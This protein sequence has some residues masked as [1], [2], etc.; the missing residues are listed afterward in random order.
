KAAPKAKDTA[1]KKATPKETSATLSAM[2]LAERIGIQFDLAWTGHFNG[3]ING[4]SGERTAA[5][6]KAFQKEYRVKESGAL[7][8]AERAQLA[9]A[10]KARQERVAWRMAD[11]KAT[12]A[13]LGLPTLQVPNV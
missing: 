8:P 3:L 7:A 9:A 6:G 1:Q 13:Q 4:E 2:P 12:G 11:D 10:S 5:A